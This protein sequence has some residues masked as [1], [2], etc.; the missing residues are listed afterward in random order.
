MTTYLDIVGR[1]PPNGCPGDDAGCP[2][3]GRAERN[4]AR[5]RDPSASVCLMGEPIQGGDQHTPRL[6]DELARDPGAEEETPDASLWD[7]PGHDGIVTDAASDPDRTDL[8]SKIGSYVSLVTFP[9]DGGA[10]MAMAQSQGAPDDVLDALGSL[11]PGARFTN[12]T[13]LW[14]ALDLGSDHRF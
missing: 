13:E 12:T 14:N 2:D 10:L 1:D 6:D 8:R 7:T 11:E 4:S 5:T 3:I 9:A